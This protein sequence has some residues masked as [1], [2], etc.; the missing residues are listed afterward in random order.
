MERSRILP[1]FQFFPAR[2]VVLSDVLFVALT[3]RDILIFWFP[4]GQ[5]S[6][7]GIVELYTRPD[8]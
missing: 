6:P 7:P 2:F 8:R 1:I 4:T 5:L 3:E